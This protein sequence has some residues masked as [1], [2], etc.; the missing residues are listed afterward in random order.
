MQTKDTKYEPLIRPEDK[1]AIWLNKETMDKY[2]P[3][4]KKFYYDP[5]RYKTYLEQLGIQYPTVLYQHDGRPVAVSRRGRALLARASFAVGDT[6]MS[7]CS[8]TTLNLASLLDHQARLIPD[9]EVLVFDTMRMTYAALAG[10]VS[11]IAAGARPHGHR[12]RR[13]RRALV[14][15]HAALPDRLL[16]HP[17]AGGVVVPLNVLLKPRE[18]A[19]HL[20]DSDARA[21]FCFE[22]TPE[23]PMAQMGR[24]A[25]DEVAAAEHFIVMTKDPAARLAGRRRADAGRADARGSR[26]RSRRRRARPTTPP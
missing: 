8:A 14:P 20:R 23:L 13:P 10:E 3:E 9:R 25:F 7:M 4:L 12:P 22:G 6:R 26:R 21:Y 17:R 15:E 2:R 5:T 19:Y 24:A 11:K 18:I 1:P 16:R